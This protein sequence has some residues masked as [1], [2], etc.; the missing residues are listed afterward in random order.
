MNKIEKFVYDILKKTPWIKLAVRNVY[1]K[2]FD[3]LP[4]EK[5]YSVSLIEIK[6]GYFFGFHDISPFSNDGNRILANCPPF[7]DHMPQKGDPLKIGFFD[8]KDGKFGKFTELGISY[9]WNFHKGCRLQWLNQECVIY[10]TIS[11]GNMVSQIT[12][13]NSLHSRTLDFPIDSIS[14]NG[15]FASSFSYERLEKYMPGYGYPY[16]DSYSFI[17]NKAPNE[18]GMYLIDMKNNSRKLIVSLSDLFKMVRDEENA[19][20]G[21]HYVT[22]SEFS[23]DNKYLSF[24]HRWVGKDTRKRY[25]RLIIYDLQKKTYFSAPTGNMVSHYVWN[26]LNQIIAYCNFKGIDC[27]ALIDVENINNSKIIGYPTLNSDGH[28]SFVNNKAFV[29]DTY[30]DKYR[31]AKLFYVNMDTD[32]IKL[33]ASLYSPEKFQSKSSYGHI[34]CDLHP[35]VSH[36]GKFVCFDTVHT[37][38]RSLAVMPLN[39]YS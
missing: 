27:H 26:D 17:E 39:I 21:Y 4:R 22:H 2:I 6:E 11:K 1:Q 13:I 37:G 18:T 33:L 32:E 31:M 36:D 23:Q 5:N 9:S 16:K 10:N 3:V 28:Q 29:T 25:T 8:F 7:N 12:N 30:P 24:L 34:A 35:R 20:F 38:K 14:K 19:T 15:T